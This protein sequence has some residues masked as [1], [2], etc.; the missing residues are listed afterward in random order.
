MKTNITI[1]SFI[2]SFEKKVAKALADDLELYYVDVNDF[3]EFNLINVNEVLTTCGPDY[4]NKIERK[5]VKTVSD[6]ENTVITLNTNMLFDK[7][8]IKSLKESSIIVY[9]Q[10]PSKMVE[11][12]SKKVAASDK[13]HLDVQNLVMEE[14][15][16][17]LLSI[18]DIV[19]P[20]NNLNEKSTIKKVV[21]E[22][23]AYYT[24]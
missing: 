20:S 8:N 1:I 4:L 13:S 24:V 3:M 19:V 9:I 7:E 12:E 11:G 16:K 23:N 15:E 6:F 5:T 21:K 10:L 18:C 14:R 17:Q 22:I 2:N